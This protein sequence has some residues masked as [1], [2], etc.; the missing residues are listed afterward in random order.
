M[1]VL[2]SSVIELVDARPIETGLDLLLNH[3]ERRRLCR[4]NTDILATDKT[5]PKL[6]DTDRHDTATEAIDPYFGCQY[7]AQL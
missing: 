7:S 3:L 1:V 6:P 4:E 2:I 5:F